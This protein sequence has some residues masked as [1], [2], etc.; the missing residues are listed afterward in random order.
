MFADEFG[1][2]TINKESL[3]LDYYADHAEAID[4]LKPS[5]H[6]A[7]NGFMTTW[8]KLGKDE[9]IET[10]DLS[11][12]EPFFFNVVN[13]IDM[14]ERNDFTDRSENKVAKDEPFG[15][16]MTGSFIVENAGEYDFQ[17]K[18]DNAAR[19]LLD[20]HLLIDGWKYKDSYH[21]K[22]RS[23]GIVLDSGDHEI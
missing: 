8:Y 23:S 1:D 16:V 14:E 22:T 9:D 15:A 21:A 10:Y 4:A 2:Q 6:T 3:G 19:V 18:A 17:M 12:K 13:D 11:K 5:T 7:V 20:G